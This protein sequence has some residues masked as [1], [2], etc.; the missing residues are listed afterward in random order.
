MRVHADSCT[1]RPC[2]CGVADEL[3]K[4]FCA[5]AEPLIKFLCEEWHPHVTVVV[6]PT[7][8]E[9]LSGEMGFTTEA[10]LVD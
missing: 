9:L 6:T 1:R 3:R 8:A 10:F 5:L 7:S 4:E 2:T